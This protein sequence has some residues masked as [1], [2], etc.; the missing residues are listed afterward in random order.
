[1]GRASFLAF[2]PCHEPGV[3]GFL[4]SSSLA[5]AECWD[6][7]ANVGVYVLQLAEHVGVF[8]RIVAFEPNPSAA[9]LLGWSTIKAR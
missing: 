2:P 6:I 5:G 7:G 3:A 8:G 1:V 9:A 4:A